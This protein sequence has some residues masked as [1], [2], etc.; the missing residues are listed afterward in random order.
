M[1]EYFRDQLKKNSMLTKERVQKIDEINKQEY[2]KHGYTAMYGEYKEG[3]VLLNFIVTPLK[4][5]EKYILIVGTTH[6]EFNNLK[7]DFLFERFEENTNLPV[8]VRRIK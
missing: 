2:A 1:K 7:K 5:N 3:D 6:R 4:E 8:L